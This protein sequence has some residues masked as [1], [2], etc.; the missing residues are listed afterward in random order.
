MTAGDIGTFDS[1]G[2]CPSNAMVDWDV[3]DTNTSNRNGSNNSLESAQPLSNP[4]SVA[5]YVKLAGDVSDFFSI[6]LSA[7]QEISLY[8]ADPTDAAR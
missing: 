1:F 2:T 5:G 8:V 4:V 7:G 6:S 3:N